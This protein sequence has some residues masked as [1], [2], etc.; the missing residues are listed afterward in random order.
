MNRLRMLTMWALRLRA[1][2]V[3]EARALARRNVV[4]A[5]EYRAALA[6]EAR[7]GIPTFSEALRGEFD[8]L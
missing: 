5:W 1:R 6:L 2:S 7:D 8:T 4:S 3:I